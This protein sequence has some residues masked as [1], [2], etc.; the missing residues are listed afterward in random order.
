MYVFRI[1]LFFFCCAERRICL[2]ITQTLHLLD[3]ALTLVVLQRLAPDLYTLL[4]FTRVHYFGI[5]LCTSA[6][7]FTCHPPMFH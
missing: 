7:N 1:V 6:T 5:I 2:Q 4:A 3:T